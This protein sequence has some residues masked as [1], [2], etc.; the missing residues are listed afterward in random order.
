MFHS[1]VLLIISPMCMVLCVWFR[2]CSML[3]SFLEG[4]LFSK[5]TTASVFLIWSHFLD[6]ITSTLVRMYMAWDEVRKNL[7]RLV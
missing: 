4:C 5:F 3:D 2:C 7:I 1:G 6:M